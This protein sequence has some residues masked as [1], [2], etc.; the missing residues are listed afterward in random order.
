[1]SKFWRS[2]CTKLKGYVEKIVKI[3]VRE[4]TK[5]V[6]YILQYQISKLAQLLAKKGVNEGVIG[7][8]LAEIVVD[9]F[10]SPIIQAPDAFSFYPQ[11]SKLSKPVGN[12]S[13]A[14]SMT[15]FCR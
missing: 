3:L 9:K 1:M 13:T 7:S 10:F 6:P 11:T 4:N 8:F 14:R 5:I 15:C 12:S 2:S